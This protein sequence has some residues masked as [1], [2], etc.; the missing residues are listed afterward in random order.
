MNKVCWE[1]MFF[2][3]LYTLLITPL[4]SE[5]VHCVIGKVFFTAVTFQTTETC[6]K[7]TAFSDRSHETVTVVCN[8]EAA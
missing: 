4:F 5:R 7:V 6:R 8:H 1:Y 2:P 3:A